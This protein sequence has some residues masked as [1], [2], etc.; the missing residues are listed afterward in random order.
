MSSSHAELKQ[1]NIRASAARRAREIKANIDVLLRWRPG[2]KDAAEIGLLASALP[3][4]Y[5]V[6]GVTNSENHINDAVGRGV[7]IVHLE[8]SLG[9]FWEAH[10][11]GWILG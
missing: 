7:D 9:I 2:W 5:L 6:R 1:L 3:L 10:L 8:Q 11:Q 4:Y